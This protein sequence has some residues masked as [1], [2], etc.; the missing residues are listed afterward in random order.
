MPSWLSL[1]D[2]VEFLG[3]LDAFCTFFIS[4]AI[5]PNK[6]CYCGVISFFGDFFSFLI[7][8][9]SILLSSVTFSTIEIVTGALLLA[10]FL[11]LGVVGDLFFGDPPSFLF[12]GDY[13]RCFFGDFFLFFGFFGDL[14]SFS[15]LLY[16]SFYV[17][18]LKS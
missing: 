6:N 17:D 7:G 16:L 3:V 5:L 12:L 4:E 9:L 18:T 14:A 1:I 10:L 13:S 15:P 2:I 8:V 11:F